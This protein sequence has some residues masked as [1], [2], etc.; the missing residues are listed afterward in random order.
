MSL[1][2]SKP[3]CLPI[4]ISEVHPPCPELWG[5]LMWPLA[6][7]SHV[8]SYHP[9]SSSPVGPHSLAASSDFP[10]LILLQSPCTHPSLCVE[11]PP[12]SLFLISLPNSSHFSAQAPPHPKC[13][14]LPVILPLDSGLFFPSTGK[15]KLL[16]LLE[17]LFFCL[18]FCHR[19]MPST[20]GSACT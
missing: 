18:G 16:C 7:L 1:P 5:S 8:I 6:Q 13:S 3:S 11:G 10:N 4:I 14:S 17:I 20:V 9:H 12:L 15:E 19:S 2:C